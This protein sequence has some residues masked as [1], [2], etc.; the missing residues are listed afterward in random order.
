MQLTTHSSIPQHREK[1]FEVAKY[2]FELSWMQTCEKAHLENI[3]GFKKW[4]KRQKKGLFAG[5]SYE[6]KMALTV[7]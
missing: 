2:K 7:Q 3:S 6:F 4:L 5:S 1:V